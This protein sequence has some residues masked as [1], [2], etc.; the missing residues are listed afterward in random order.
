MLDRQ[1]TVTYHRKDAESPDEYPINPLALVQRGS[2]IY[3]ICTIKTYADIRILVLHRVLSAT[4]LGTPTVH[5]P[6]FDLDEYLARGAFGWG[7]G[8]I[9]QLKALFTTEAGNHLHETPLSID[10]EISQASDGRLR[11]TAS[12]PDNKQLLWWLLGFGDGVEVEAPKELR[13]TIKLSL[14]S[15]ARRYQC[16]G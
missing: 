7:A 13:D 9:I 16:E 14:A 6:G 4:L 8:Q 12:V 11:V 15:A 5:L 3:L 10:Q 2:L 1:C